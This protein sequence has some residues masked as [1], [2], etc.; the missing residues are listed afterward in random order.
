[1][2]DIETTLAARSAEIIIGVDP[3]IER[4]GIAVLTRSTGRVN[5]F[6]LPFAEAI[7][8]ITAITGRGERTLVLVEAGWLNQSN[9][10]FNYT[11]SKAK[12]AAMGRSVGMN[13][14]C[15]IL[16]CEMLAH[17]HVPHVAVKP[18]IKRWQGREGKITQEEI[19]AFIPGLPKRTN[20][21]ERDA[22]LIAWV[23]A[24]Y[25]IRVKPKNKTK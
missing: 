16:L 4:N 15:G 2:N 14:E 17:H 1:M 5:L 25:P 6:A 19:S 7:E 10:H 22:A 23:A 3:D 9:W 12:C 20:Q 21:E 8:R 11:D 24:G 13:H 18:L